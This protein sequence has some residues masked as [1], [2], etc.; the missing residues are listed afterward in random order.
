MV[1]RG[2]CQPAREGAHFYQPSWFADMRGFEYLELAGPQPS[3]TSAAPLV[4]SAEPLPAAPPAA[5]DG[6]HAGGEEMAP[7][8]AAAVPA[9]KEMQDGSS[10]PTDTFTCAARNPSPSAEVQLV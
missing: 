3:Q 4:D 10:P 8:A 5:W 1:C 7:A 2:P 9:V 6:A